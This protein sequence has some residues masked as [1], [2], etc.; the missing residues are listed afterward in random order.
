MT[1]LVPM[2]PEVYS[3]YLITSVAGYAEENV[4]SGRWPAEGAVARS[5]IEFQEL[6][7]Q[8]LATPDHYLFEIRDS[9][10]GPTVGY[11][12]FAAEV[13]HGF[14]G[15]FVYDVEIKKEYRRLGHALRAFRALE[16]HAAALGLATIGLHVFGQNAG[17]QALYQKLG[18]A[19]TGM[20]MLKKLDAPGRRIS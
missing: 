19:V 2:R 16:T 4:S 7:P 12:W 1:E 11:I 9:A 6:L 8:G 10:S 3:E 18:Y 5:Q 13:R 17:A 15:A 14:R 20:N